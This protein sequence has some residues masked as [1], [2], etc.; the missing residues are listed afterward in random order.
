M[1]LNS[2]LK[3][4]DAL[5]AKSKPLTDKAGKTLENTNEALG[6]AADELMAGFDRIHKLLK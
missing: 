6:V 3:E 4:W 5:L 2:K 1:R